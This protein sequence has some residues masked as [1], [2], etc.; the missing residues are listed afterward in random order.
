MSS[1]SVLSHTELIFFLLSAAGDAAEM[2][3]TRAGCRQTAHM[4]KYAAGM[5]A[6]GRWIEA[7]D[8]TEDGDMADGRVRHDNVDNISQKA[9]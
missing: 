7:G 6:D 8:T 9:P 1:I 5:R 4:Y 2:R 3:G